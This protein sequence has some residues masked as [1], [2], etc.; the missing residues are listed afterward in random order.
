VAP[1]F[2]AGHHDGLRIHKHPLDR[3]DVSKDELKGHV[4]WLASKARAKTT[5]SAYAK[6]WNQEV[7]PHCRW[8]QLEPWK[9]TS[10]DLANLLAWHEMQGKAGEV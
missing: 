3:F 10:I 4:S 8:L 9:L 7:V 5:A 6:L 2:T 1:L